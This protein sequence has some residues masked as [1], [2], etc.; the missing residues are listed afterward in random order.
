LL[1]APPLDNA[2][3]GPRGVIGEAIG[4]QRFDAVQDRDNGQAEVLA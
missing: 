2:L 4:M 1:G 3:H